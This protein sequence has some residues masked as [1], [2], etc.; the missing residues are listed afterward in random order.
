M[1]FNSRDQLHKKPYGAA[2]A[3]EN[4][5]MKVDAAG[6]PVLELYA[7]GCPQPTLYTANDRG[8]FSFSVEKAGLYFYRFSTDCGYIERGAGGVGVVT[9][10]CGCKF[11]LTVYDRYTTPERFRGGVMYQIFPDSFCKSGQP[12]SNVPTDREYA[13]LG[14]LPEYRP[15]KNGR[16]SNRYYG[17]DLAG[18]VQKLP[19][20]ESLGVTVI[21][22]NPIFE[23]HSNHRYNTADYMKIDPLLGTLADFKHLCSEAGKRGIAIILDGVF[24]HTGDDSIYFNRQGRYGENGAFGGS[25]SKYYSW[26][27]FNG[28]R[29]SAWWNIPTLPEVNENDPDFSEF[30]CG[31]GGVIDYWLSNGASGFRLDVAD[32]LPDSF[33][34]KIK[35]AVRRHPD[36]LLIG[37][38][39]EDASNK[40][41]Y[42]SRRRYLLGTE[43]DSV[44]NYPFKEAIIRFL[45]SGDAAG[46]AETVETI[47]E[48]YPRPT[49]DVLM[50]LLST[51]DTARIINALSVPNPPA[52][53]ANLQR[54]VI[55]KDDYLRGIELLKLAFVL[56]F[57]LPGFPCVY[58]GDEIGMQG[59][60]DP[61]C[62]AY[63]RW[64]DPPCDLRPLITSLSAARRAHS[65]FK[66]GDCRFVSRTGSLVAF[67]RQSGES[68]VLVAVN[69]GDSAARIT[70][71][72]HSYKVEPWR[73][74][75]APVV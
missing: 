73:Y 15:D 34:E 5:F 20:L 43:L 30:I 7:D 53:K 36:C 56:S 44:M 68:R 2:E 64:D 59:F 72:G 61:F 18:I 21:Y 50:N 10:G 55:S 66:G 38:V 28:N 52:G 48:N 33:I 16:Y 70:V 58:Y 6:H 19:Y 54:Y 47:T 12:K 8:E 60:G 63:Y 42:G 13:S 51:H 45:Q 71:G 67:V 23:A 31:R 75:I 40:I 57:T 74:I 11:Q 65:A 39:W 25:D 14:E 26:Y 41:S 35:I 24:S 49:Q 4:I 69:R 62:R 27:N 1:Y 22:L 3:G 9:N 37:E 32:E 46:F 29:Y 17:G